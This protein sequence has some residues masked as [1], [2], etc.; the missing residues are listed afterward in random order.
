MNPSAKIIAFRN[1]PI[2]RSLTTEQ[3]DLLA[4]SAIYE[5][6]AKNAA[7]YDTGSVMDYVYVIEKV[8]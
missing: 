3:L 7:I 2:F 1:M 5:K 6:V 4:N 8:V